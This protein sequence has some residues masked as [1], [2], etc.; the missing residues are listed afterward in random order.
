MLIVQNPRNI[1]KGIH[2]L[3]MKDGRRFFE[4]DRFDASIPKADIADL[5]RKG[6]LAEV[7]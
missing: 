1:P 2:I 4:G 3:T 7:N 5:V 6:F